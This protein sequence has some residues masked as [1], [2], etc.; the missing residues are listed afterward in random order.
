MKESAVGVFHDK[1]IHVHILDCKGSERK[2]KRGKK[3]RYLKTI[4]I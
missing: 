3:R 1:C 4:P 2:R